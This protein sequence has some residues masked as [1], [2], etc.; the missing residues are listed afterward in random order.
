MN[1]SELILVQPSRGERLSVLL[2]PAVPPMI[3]AQPPLSALHY[4]SPESEEEKKLRLEMGF[5][6]LADV[7]NSEDLAMDD[8]PVIGHSGDVPTPQPQTTALQ[9]HNATP[10]M[11]PSAPT[12]R[13]RAIP[14]PHESLAAETIRAV[15]LPSSTVL[16]A[17]GTVP[18][19]NPEG[20]DVDAPASTT[21]PLSKPSPL[22]SVPIISHG[23]GSKLSAQ[24]LT[25][26]TLGKR[27]AIAQD[28]DD[29]EPI[30]ELDS[31][32]SIG[33]ASDDEYDE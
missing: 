14:N 13:D 6:Q 7:V 4:F 22:E 19:L 17:N 15:T 3:R 33:F 27:P 9:I 30:P 11:E 8:E 29:D 12:P 21:G 18:V 20:M 31:G 5:G 2:H 10:A 23:G 25:A 32:S 16:P 24:T 28:D 1:E 26:T